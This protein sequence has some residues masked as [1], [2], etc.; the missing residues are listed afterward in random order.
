M[1]KIYLHLIG[2][3]PT[4]GTGFQPAFPTNDYFWN[5][6]DHQNFDLLGCPRCIASVPLKD[7]NRLPEKTREKSLEALEFILEKSDYL[8]EWP[9]PKNPQIEG[10]NGTEGL[11]YN[12][13]LGILRTLA[14]E[15]NLE[16]KEQII[17]FGALP[18]CRPTNTWKRYLQLPPE[19]VNQKLPENLQE[20]V[21]AP[22]DITGILQG[23]VRS[24]ERIPEWEGELDIYKTIGL[25]IRGKDYL[26]PQTVPFVTVHIGEDARTYNSHDI[27]CTIANEAFLQLMTDNPKRA[28]DMFKEAVFDQFHYQQQDEDNIYFDEDSF[29]SETSEEIHLLVAGDQANQQTLEIAKKDLTEAAKRICISYLPQ[30]MRPMRYRKC[31]FHLKHISLT[32]QGITLE[33]TV[34]TTEETHKVKINPD[35]TP[36]IES[37]KRRRTKP[38]TTDK[39]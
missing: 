3:D 14:R 36:Q 38:K 19:E 17:W 33:A 13:V 6:T 39:G 2:T 18:D 20:K 26:I 4:T 10:E 27:P 7:V 30:I 31:D 23:H 15:S 5:T 12:V 28:N 22:K 24:F 32:K 34:Q 16:S 11:S 29:L 1:S 21:V 25:N 8:E 9:N 35:G 37:N